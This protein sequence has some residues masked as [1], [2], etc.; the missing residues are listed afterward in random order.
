MLF[1]SAAIGQST[2]LRQSMKNRSITVETTCQ[3]LIP[4]HFRPKITIQSGKRT[5]AVKPSSLKSEHNDWS[6]KTYLTNALLNVR[7]KGT[8]KSATS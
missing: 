1:T 7:Y 3:K 8:L 4:V 2:Y 6:D 5:N